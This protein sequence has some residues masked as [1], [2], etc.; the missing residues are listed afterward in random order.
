MFQKT[1]ME[2]KFILSLRANQMC[3]FSLMVLVFCC[4][5]FLFCFC[6]C[7]FRGGISFEK[8]TSTRR[9]FHWKI[10]T[11]NFLLYLFT[12]WNVLL[13]IWVQFRSLSIRSSLHGISGKDFWRLD[14]AHKICIL[15]PS[16]NKTINILCC[17]VKSIYLQNSFCFYNK[18][19]LE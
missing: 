6:F 19:S 2:F 14:L 1:F 4:C 15:S 17:F 11:E 12:L 13:M 7:F 5:V 9:G 18:L 8:L 10:I 3:L 16:G